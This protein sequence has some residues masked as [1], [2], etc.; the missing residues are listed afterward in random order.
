[1]LPSGVARLSLKGSWPGIHL[2]RMIDLFAWSYTKDRPSSQLMVQGERRVYVQRL[3]GFGAW[4]DPS[5][6][7]F[8]W[9]QLHYILHYH[10]F[11]KKQRVMSHGFLGTPEM[12]HP[13]SPSKV[14]YWQTRFDEEFICLPKAFWIGSSQVPR[15]LGENSLEGLQGRGCNP[16]MGYVDGVRLT[17]SWHPCAQWFFWTDD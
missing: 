12:M 11:S 5:V 4:W 1:M 2:L 15:S 16:R 17:T 8:L 13:H 10:R 14:D 6:S 7:L 9:I 3:F